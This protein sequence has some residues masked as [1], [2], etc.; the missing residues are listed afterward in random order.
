[1]HC[2]RMVGRYLVG[3]F[4]YA[5]GT[6]PSSEH[7]LVGKQIQ[8]L[9]V[10]AVFLDAAYVDDAYVVHGPLVEGSPCQCHHHHHPLYRLFLESL[11]VLCAH[12][13]FHTIYMRQ[14]CIVDTS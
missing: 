2:E 6:N 14:F 3:V 4:R 7:G 12:V 1:M 5:V 11:Q 8:W 13:E 10:C 9:D